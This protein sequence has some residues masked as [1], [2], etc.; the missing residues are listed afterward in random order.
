MIE[1]SRELERFLDAE[2]RVTIWPSRLRHRLMVLDY[3]AGHFEP[4]KCY[5]EAEVN[6]ILN[7]LHAF[8]DWAGLRRA[9]FDHGFMDRLGDGSSYWRVIP[10]PG[11]SKD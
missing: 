3:L 2:R 7:R 6:A 9:L 1:A 8:E 11:A 4:G 10:P 5:S